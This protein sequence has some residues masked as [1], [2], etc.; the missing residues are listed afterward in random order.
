MFCVAF[1]VELA[2]GGRMFGGRRFGAASRKGRRETEW[3]ATEKSAGNAAYGSVSALN[4]VG[5]CGDTV[6]EAAADANVSEAAGSEAQYSD[7]TG[8]VFCTLYAPGAR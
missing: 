5:I 3:S 1:G 4:G 6:H 8:S 7:G 2:V